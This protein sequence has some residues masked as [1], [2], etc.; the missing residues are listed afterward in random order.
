MSAVVSVVLSIALG[1]FSGVFATLIGLVL[2]E[3]AQI[4]KEVEDD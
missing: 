3:D 2:F 1:F 4:K